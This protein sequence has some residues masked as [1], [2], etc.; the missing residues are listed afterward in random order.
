MTWEYLKR[1]ILQEMEPPGL[2]QG[3]RNLENAFC[4]DKFYMEKYI[5][6]RWFTH[7]IVRQR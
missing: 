6:I 5:Q 1:F 2:K 7:W 4:I 3:A